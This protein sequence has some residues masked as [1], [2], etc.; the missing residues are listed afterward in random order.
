M[1]LLIASS[2]VLQVDVGFSSNSMAFS[3]LAVRNINLSSL[4]GTAP[5]LFHIHLDRKLRVAV[6]FAVFVCCES[7]CWFFLSNIFYGCHPDQRASFGEE[8]SREM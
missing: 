2:F 3:S 6:L 8:P 1:I 5:I 7:F 4:T